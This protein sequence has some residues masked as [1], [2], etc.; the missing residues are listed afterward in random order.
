MIVW[1]A[2]YPRSGSLLLRQIL[3]FTMN[4]PSYHLGSDVN[5]INGEYSR[6]IDGP[7]E[8]FV[9]QSAGARHPVLIK[10]HHHPSDQHPALYVV[11]DGRA[12]IASFLKF[13]RTFSPDEQTT[14]LRL[15]VGDHYFGGW[16]E[17]YA[18]WHDRSQVPTILT[19]RYEALVDA[20]AEL[21]ARIAAFIGYRGEIAPWVNPIEE[22]RARHPGIV[23]PGKRTWEPPREW[24]HVCDAIFWAMHGELMKQL[25]LDDGDRVAAPSDAVACALGEIVP[26]MSAAVA[27]IRRLQED[28]VAKEAVIS[29]LFRVCAERESAIK[30]LLADA[31]TRAPL[32]EE[33]R[34]RRT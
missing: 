13:E 1:L 32:V 22:W 11:R 30:R 10:T 6:Q 28:C 9:A 17:H 31:S 16:S 33:M 18:A 27:R 15:V 7:L 26:L 12:A 19:L 29:E 14:M 24:T 23:G 5:E 4:Q 20:S 21:L 3:Y 8:E 2:S 34:Q 25:G